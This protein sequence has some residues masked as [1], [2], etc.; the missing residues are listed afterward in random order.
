M[1]VYMIHPDDAGGDGRSRDMIRSAAETERPLESG[2]MSAPSP[3]I[4]AVLCFSGLDPTGGAGLQADIEA[5]V[6]MG[7]HPLPIATSLT[8]QDTRDVRAVMPLDTRHVV[9][10]ARTVLADIPIAA[11]K[12][13]LLGSVEIVEALHDV[14]VDC[15]GTPVVLDPIHRA[16][17]GSVLAGDDLTSA[18]VSRL[19]PLVTVLTPNTHEARRLAP[20]AETITAA[21]GQLVS[22]GC[23]YVL[24]TGADEET[25]HVVNR[26]YGDRGLIESFE[27]PRIEGVFH[28]SG[29]TLAAAVA[30]GL[31]RGASPRAAVA[32]AQQFTCHAIS[33]GYRIGAGQLVPDR[34]YRARGC[35]LGSR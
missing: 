26:L 10:Q 35:G 34:L 23:R 17:G 11:V 2:A 18:I 13:G 14:L 9:A 4:P 16:G 32:E 15:E 22:R 29:C 8:V 7:G 3:R 1:C 21:A 27:W 5:I 31:A 25:P 33:N 30:A 12:I 19:V 20:G 28:G 24:V 6:S